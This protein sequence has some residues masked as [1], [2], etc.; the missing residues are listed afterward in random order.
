M[1]T[2]EIIIIGNYYVPGNED[3]KTQRNVTCSNDLKKEK[4]EEEKKEIQLKTI[5]Q[6]T[7]AILKI[8]ITE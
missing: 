2:T 8:H 5:V 4:E 3:T 7:S 6:C 1:T